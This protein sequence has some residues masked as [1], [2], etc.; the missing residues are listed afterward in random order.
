MIF[1]KLW[2]QFKK[3]RPN[4]IH[5]ELGFSIMLKNFELRLPSGRIQRYFTWDEVRNL[6]KTN[7]FPEGWRPM[8]LSEFSALKEYYGNKACYDTFNFK[9]VGH[10]REMNIDQYHN[11]LS[12]KCVSN[13][14]FCCWTCTPEE[15]SNDDTRYNY[16]ISLGKDPLHSYHSYFANLKINN[17]YQLRLVKSDS[18]KEDGFFEI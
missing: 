2:N 1:K 7:A 18:L 6:Y 12:S 8:K 11:T 5:T 3:N 9:N 14:E 17:A 16:L 4:A 15:I 10:I 13:S